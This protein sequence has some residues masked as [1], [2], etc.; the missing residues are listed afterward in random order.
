MSLIIYSSKQFI[1]KH[2]LSYYNPSI[3]NNITLH[4]NLN[5]DINSTQLSEEFI[6]SKYSVFNKELKI[7]L[8]KANYGEKIKVIIIFNKNLSKE[9]RIQTLN[10]IFNNYEIINNYNIIPGMCIICNSNDLIE[11]EKIL[12]SNYKIKKI[13]SSN[14]HE[15]T[16]IKD[17]FIKL[18]SIEQKNYDN[19]WLPAIG[20]EDLEYDGSGV[21]VAVIDTG[22][23]YHPDIIS[24]IIDSRNFAKENGKTNKYDHF[25]DYGHGT[26]CA[27]II[28]GNGKISS[29]K[30]RGVAPGVYLINAKAA[31]SSGYLDDNNI[32]DAID[33]CV[34][35]KKVDI[36]SMSFGD[37]VPTN[38]GPLKLAISTAVEKGVICVAAA[39]NAGPKYYTGGAPASILESISVGASNKKN[40]SASF[41]SWG[42]TYSYL[43]YPDIIAP[44]VD[45]ISIENLGSILSNYYRY[46]GNYFDYNG[47]SGYIPLSGTS[48]AC[49]MVSG[50]LAILKQAYP[51]ITPE[52]ARIALIEGAKKKNRD[53]ENYLKAGAGL[54]N[55]KATLNFLKK[56][57]GDI[58]NIS[59]IYPNN[60]PIKPF[61]LINF[62]G[63]KQKFNLTI[64]SGI[65]NE[66]KLEIPN[67]IKG[68]SMTLEKNNIIFP[69]RGIKT[70]TLEIEINLNATPGIREFQINL[71]KNKIIYDSINFKLNIRLPRFRILMDSF[72]GLNDWFST[73]STS[74]QQIEME[75][76]I[77]QL[78][79]LN[80]S[81]NFFMDRWIPNFNSNLN[82]SLLTKEKL[83]LYDLVILQN[84]VLPYTSS[85]FSALT[86]FFNNGGNILF[87]GTRSQDLCVENINNLFNHLNS[88]IFLEKNNIIDETNVGL[89][90][91][92]NS[93]E[94]NEFADH[95]L[96]KDVNEIYWRIGC[97]FDT[98]GGAQSLAQINGKTVIANFDGSSL[99]KGQIITFGSF[100]WLLNNNFDKKEYSDNHLN[101]LTN[102]IDFFIS[103][104]K[105]LENFSINIGIKSEFLFQNKTNL[106]IYIIN[107]T[108]QKGINSLLS[109][110]TIN[111]TLINLES[112]KTQSIFLINN[113]FGVYYNK[114]IEIQNPNFTSYL[115][116]ISILVKGKLFYRTFKIHFLN[117]SKTPQLL[118]YSILSDSLFRNPLLSNSIDI[119]TNKANCCVSLYISIT[120]GSIYDKKQTVSKEFLK[121]NESQHRIYSTEIPIERNYPAGKAIYYIVINSSEGFQNVFIKRDFFIIENKKPEINE[122]K[123]YFRTTPFNEIITSEGIIV[124]N[125]QQLEEIEFIISA[126]DGRSYEDNV[127]ELIVIIS[128]M[129]ISLSYNNYVIFMTP[130]E[131][132]YL[133]LE[134]NKNFNIFKG[135]FSVPDILKYEILNQTIE[136]TTE[137]YSIYYGLFYVIIQDLDGGYCEFFIIVEITKETY[138]LF[139][140]LFII[141]IISIITAIIIFFI[142]RKKN[143]EN[144]E[145]DSKKSQSITEQNK[146]FYKISEKKSTL[147]IKYCPFCGKLL[148]NS[149]RVCKYCQKSF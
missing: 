57:E 23:G 98:F 82:A 83:S 90:L 29:G 25:D 58:N 88:G 31:D 65:A 96:F 149:K 43:G 41:S 20:A 113:G 111:A 74:Y 130:Y 99:G 118:N 21:K 119:Q 12:N 26:H 80:C 53:Q 46:L 78:N 129:M 139:L 146:S 103:K 51:T 35:N 145:V 100:D 42:P 105:N 126:K 108:S 75:K 39:G 66:F 71:T 10:R 147:I 143:I 85:E 72:H 127:K 15:L 11:K 124:Q 13:F 59:R 95:P 61:D 107:Q 77:R 81:V 134:Y 37:N 50:A 122:E 45:I 125:I 97:S 49:P 120:S 128:F 22:I 56:K 67:R 123:S 142:I 68:I 47:E 87:L 32:I 36:I 4:K 69:K 6:S 94:I 92:I 1:P 110:I 14:T 76:I 9:E 141:I 89:G 64:I 54:L 91:I 106:S 131:Y 55:V 102:L 3:L 121:I 48:M 33:W 2:N 73:L 18:N 5:D 104:S 19:W 62:P 144:F 114:S 117:K 27:G 24:R 109:G 101:L 93:Q 135:I 133:E 86:E 137:T 44:G 30:F 8:Q 16:Y 132:S 79:K 52:T 7:K 40:R 140:I 38:Y 63:T 138:N 60:L 116:N 28:G 148:S 70:V 84:P 115:I 17:N 112:N 34:N 136:K